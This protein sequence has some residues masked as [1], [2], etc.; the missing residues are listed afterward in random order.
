MIGPIYLNVPEVRA[1]F[2]RNGFV[3]SLRRPRGVGETNAVVGSYYDNQVIARVNVQLVK[4]NITAPEQLVDYAFQSGIKVQA[5]LSA[6]EFDTMLIAKKW[7]ELAH[8]KSGET[9]NLYKIMK[10]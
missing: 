9:L 10:I 4:E 3:Y 5:T 7:L 2:E 6:F 1:Y 8:S